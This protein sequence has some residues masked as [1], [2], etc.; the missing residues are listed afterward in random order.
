MRNPPPPWFRE[1]LTRLADRHDLT[2]EQA[3]PVFEH[4]LGEPEPADAAA[5]LVALRMKGESATELAAAA[6]VLRHRMTPFATG[7][8]DVLD[9]C[10]PGGTGDRTFNISTAAAI[11][12]AGAGVPV[13]KHG[14]RAVS[15]LCGSADVLRE[16][17]LP[18]E[19]GPTWSRRCLDA[20]G[21]AFCFAPHFHPIL[22]RLGDLRRRLGVRTIFNSLGPL[23][24]PAG[25]AYQLLGLGRPEQLDPMAGALAILGTRHALV[26]CGPDGFDEVSL[27]GPT[28]VRQVRGS[29]ITSLTWTPGDFGLEPCRVEEF[30]I[31]D[32]AASAAVIRNVLNDC[33]GPARRI[34]VANAAAALL[35][36]ERV[37]SL[38]DGVRQADEA[39]RSGKAGEVLERLRAC[40]TDVSSRADSEPH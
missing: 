4:L 14:N 7:R 30:R 26:V 24:N 6:A 35:A 19:S 25:A 31:A 40:S 5:L 17:G 27:S 22:A 38:R 16:L 21:L 12:A 11:V 18:I 34:V 39:I 33:P 28:A 37:P 32:A 29:T 15:S 3:R 10:G 13:V 2:D 8:D 9:T 23:A 20:A 36:A 1:I